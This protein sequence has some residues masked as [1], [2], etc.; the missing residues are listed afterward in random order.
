MYNNRMRHGLVKPALIR[1]S[2]G[3]PPH[4]FLSNADSFASSHD[5]SCAATLWLFQHFCSTKAWPILILNSLNC[6]LC[7]ILFPNERNRWHHACFDS[8]INRLW[9]CCKLKFGCWKC[10]KG[11]TRHIKHQ[12]CADWGYCRSVS[13]DRRMLRVSFM[14]QAQTWALEGSRVTE[15]PVKAPPPPSHFLSSDKWPQHELF[16]SCLEKWTLPSLHTSRAFPPPL[17]MSANVIILSFVRSSG[18]FAG[19]TSRR[20]LGAGI[21]MQAPTSCPSFPFIYC[22]FFLCSQSSI[23]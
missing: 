13:V 18:G 15:H 2:V 22:L 17:H 14:F 4:S 9:R 21:Q 16:I 19:R 11:R 8:I 10:I 23:W 7:C 5:I 12:R 6:C 20:I 1:V 3:A